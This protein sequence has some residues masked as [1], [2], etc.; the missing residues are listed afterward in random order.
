MKVVKLVL[1]VL[2]LLLLVKM[3]KGTIRIQLSEQDNNAINRLCEL[4]F[5][6]DIVI[7]VYFCDKNEEVAADILFRDM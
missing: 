6:R 2:L 4:G 3:N 7:Q 5:E 1:A